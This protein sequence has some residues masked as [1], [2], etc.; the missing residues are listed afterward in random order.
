MY[1]LCIYF[2]SSG[3]YLAADFRM[4]ITCVL[5]FLGLIVSFAMKFSKL[6]QKGYTNLAGILT[7][8]VFLGGKKFLYITY[9][10]HSYLLVQCLDLW[11][12]WMI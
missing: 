8:T 10:L 5:L 12:L 2:F 11:I 9:K 4:V 3:N 1:L 6:F 7:F